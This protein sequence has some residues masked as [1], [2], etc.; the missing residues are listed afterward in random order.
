M[1]CPDRNFFF[2][3]EIKSP[4]EIC[5]L[6]EDF[7]IFFDGLSAVTSF[8]SFF[9]KFSRL[10]SLWKERKIVL[11]IWTETGDVFTRDVPTSHSADNYVSELTLTLRG[12]RRPRLISCPTEGVRISSPH[13][14]CPSF[15]TQAEPLH[16]LNLPLRFQPFTWGK[17][18]SSRAQKE[19][20]GTWSDA[21]M[22]VTLLCVLPI[23]EKQC[24]VH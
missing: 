15:V 4:E 21:P 17:C 12:F 20:A 19:R 24:H 2:S 16:I 7:C 6:Q 1:R 8:E 10:S 22:A 11:G 3:W 18:C 9:I 14:H 13:W 5:S 23:H